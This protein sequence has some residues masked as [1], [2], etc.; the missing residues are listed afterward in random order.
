[1][2]TEPT[3]DKLIALRLTAMAT[4]WTE[5]DKSPQVASLTFDERFGMLVDAEYMARDNRRITRLL[6]D[7][8][9]RIPT[10]CVEDIEASAA[11]GLD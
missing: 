9:L 8:Q 5:Q 11:R 7:A 1:M 10:A 4:A 6:K 2:L 3:M